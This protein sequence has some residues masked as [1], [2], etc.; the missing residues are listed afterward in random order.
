MTDWDPEQ[1]EFDE[2]AFEGRARLFPLPDLVLFPHVMQPLHIFEPRYREMVRD[3]LASDRLIATARLQP[4]WEIEYDQRPPIAPVACLGK[5]VTEH[6]LDD[7]RFN[8]LLLGVR[9]VQIVRELETTGTFRVAEVEILHDRVSKAEREKR[10][11]LRERLLST[12]EGSLP[13]GKGATNTISALLEEHVPL[14]V[15]VDLIAF[16]A[17]LKPHFKQE[18]LAE[19]NV[20]ARAEAVLQRLSQSRGRQRSWPNPLG[21]FPPPFSAN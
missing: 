10:R 4:G 11:A 12:V 8:I 14:G 1:F 9:R 17:D 21:Q 3:A 2:A 7:G 19:T 5:I 6:R 13:L 18:L 20:V 16:T 15:L